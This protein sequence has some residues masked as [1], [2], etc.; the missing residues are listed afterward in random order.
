MVRDSLESHESEI[1]ELRERLKDVEESWN[2]ERS[3]SDELGKIVEQVRSLSLSASLA[4]P[5]LSPTH[6]SGEIGCTNWIERW[7]WRCRRF[8]R[9]E[10]CLGKTFEN[11]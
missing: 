10:N 4:L 11:S 8:T 7:F 2:H 1:E 3:R 9:W 6:A 5:P